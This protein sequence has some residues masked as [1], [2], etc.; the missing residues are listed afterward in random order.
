M[1][2]SKLRFAHALVMGVLFGRGDL[3]QRVTQAFKM[4]LTHGFLLAGFAFVYKA[5]RHI[6]RVIFK[7]DSPWLSLIAGFIGSQ[8]YFAHKSK[9]VMQINK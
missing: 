9:E 8:W 3:K 6:L 1:Y 2:G 5:V 7:M 4:A